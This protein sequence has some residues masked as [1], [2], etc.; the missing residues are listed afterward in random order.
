L[1]NHQIPSIFPRALHFEGKS[2]VSGLDVSK[3]L[4]I[5]HE[6]I[7]LSHPSGASPSDVAASVGGVFHY[8]LALGQW[9]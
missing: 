5:P 2:P 1:E 9:M 3:Q 4:R 8:H 7:K 6:I